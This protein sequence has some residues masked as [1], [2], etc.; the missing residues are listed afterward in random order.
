MTIKGLSAGKGCAGRP[1]SSL[2]V[3]FLLFN[4]PVHA[5]IVPAAFADITAPNG[6]NAVP[7]LAASSEL[8]FAKTELDAMVNISKLAV[9]IYFFIIILFY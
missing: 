2:F 8:T 5:G 6:V 9:V 7:N 1:E 3:E 4:P